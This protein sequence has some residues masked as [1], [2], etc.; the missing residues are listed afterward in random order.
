[1]T[2]IYTTDDQTST[3]I[4]SVTLEAG[5]EDM[6]RVAPEGFYIRGVKVPVDDK[7]ALRVYN[8]F[9]QW[10]SWAQLTQNNG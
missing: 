3:H 7:E 6:L 2:S 4:K 8:A 9:Q 5:G 10:L 1:M